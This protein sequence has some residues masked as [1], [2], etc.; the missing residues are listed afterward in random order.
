MPIQSPSQAQLDGSNVVRFP[1]E[2]RMA[3]KDAPRRVLQ[4]LSQRLRT[5]EKSADQRQPMT[6]APGVVSQ[7]SFPGR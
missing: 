5:G 7:L 6:F 3:A 4:I 1:V 2:R